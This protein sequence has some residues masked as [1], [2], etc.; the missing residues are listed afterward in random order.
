M[1]EKTPDDIFSRI[2]V[3]ASDAIDYTPVFLFTP[4]FA[5]WADIQNN[6]IEQCLLR[7]Y[8][9]ALPSTSHIHAVTAIIDRLPCPTQGGSEHVTESEGVSILLAWG[10]NIQGKAVAPRA[11]R[12][13]ETEEPTLLFSFRRGLEDGQASRQPSHE[14][15]LRLANT[16]FLN[17]KENTLFGNRWAYDASSRELKLEASMDLST[18]SVT[19]TP[20][21]IRSSVAIPLHPVGERRTVIS[22]MGNILRQ[23][24]KHA[25][26]NSNEP[27]P[28][29]S[30][31]EK[32]LPRYIAEHDIA[33]QR[34]S[35]WAL[36]EKSRESSYNK[37]EHSQSSLVKAIEGG[38]TL[39]RVMSGGGGWGK[40][41]GLLSLD[42]EMS[43]ARPSNETMKP[44][45]EVL[46]SNDESLAAGDAASSELPEFMQDLSTLS[47]AAEPGD[48]VQFF[49]S[50]ERSDLPVH[51]NPSE[52]SLQCSFGVVSDADAISNRPTE[53]KDMKVLPDYFGALSEKAVTYLQPLRGS[54]SDASES[55]TKIDVPGSRPFFGSLGCTSAIV[56]T[57]FG[58]A[59]GTAKAGV[60]VCSMGV[61]RPDLIVKNIVPVVMAGIIGIY[62]LVVSVLVANNL[63]QKVPLYTAL[64]QLGAGLAVGLAG[65]AAGF[66]IGIVGDAGVRGT[67]QQPRLYVGMI[68]ILIFA[69][70]LGLYGLIVA[71]LMNSRATLD[72]QC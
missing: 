28:A 1:L 47:Q 2:P 58:A 18:C 57:C 38:A 8:C 27:M 42:P 22:S 53:H 4:A 64:V 56:F 50:V 72:A 11:L 29:S 26:G 5:R 19:M 33:D 34:I 16:I 30:E 6:F 63:S 13:L 46:S 68:L 65:L 15:G 55:R 69:E 66:A 61:L 7:F 60:G 23:I 39:H 48:Y 44:L 14:I 31:L 20:N 40:K 3:A 25:G 41:Q 9:N 54:Q 70:V 71:L 32:V 43:F 52:E 24:T 21:N 10:E 45:K 62:G 36:I 37:A 17:G 35:V 12:S 67:A 59:Y 51:S 49:A